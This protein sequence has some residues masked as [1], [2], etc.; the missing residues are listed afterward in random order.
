M[1]LYK[2]PF[3]FFPVR[4]V[5]ARDK[6][7]IV[8]WLDW[9]AKQDVEVVGRDPN[10]P[11]GV[12]HI[13]EVSKGTLGFDFEGLVAGNEYAEVP[14]TEDFVAKIRLESVPYFKSYQ[15]RLKPQAVGNLAAVLT[16]HGNY[17]ATSY[18]PQDVFQALRVCDISGWEPAAEEHI[19]KINEA[20]QQ[21]GAGGE[22]H[23]LPLKCTGKFN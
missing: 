18:V 8:E 20:L 15:S 3:A 4:D 6:M 1:V 5:Y 11:A 9:F 2:L 17:K 12:E 19:K 13:I 22:C 21:L 16:H 23:L 10:A 7:D 14:L